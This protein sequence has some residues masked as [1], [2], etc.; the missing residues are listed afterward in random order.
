M[1]VN[2]QLTERLVGFSLSFAESGQKVDILFRELLGPTDSKLIGRLE[3]MHNTVFGKIPGLPEPTSI[4]HLLVVIRPDLSAAAYVNE[5]KITALAKP[6]RSIKAGEQV[7]VSDI[8]DITRV[9]IGVKIDPR[10][11]V[12]VVRSFRWRRS[13]FYDFGPMSPEIGPRKFDIEQALAQ[14]ELLLLGLPS[15][16]PDILQAKSKAD[17]MAGGIQRLKMLLEQ[18]IEDEAQYQELLNQHPWMLLGNYSAP[19]RHTKMDDATIPDFT[20]TRSYDQ[21]HDII[22]L[23]HPFLTIFK[24]DRTLSAE[25]NDAW[26]QAERYVDLAIRQRAYLFDRKNLRFENPRCLLIIGHKLTEEGLHTIRSKESLNRHI[27]VLNYDQLLQGAE[28][29]LRL[30][31]EAGNQIPLGTI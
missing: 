20:G 28:H 11:C 18:K 17:H 26:N 5:L 4:D 25:F 27:T 15:I 13:L 7:L 21:C 30:V 10:D 31:R 14:Q 8:T 12:V 2:F 24:K 9:N 19:M 29:M 3:S 6:N 1:P 16:S 22:E 23:K